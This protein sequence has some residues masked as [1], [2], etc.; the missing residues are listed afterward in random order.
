MFQGDA[1][2]LVPVANA[3]A[4]ANLLTNAGKDCQYVVYPGAQHNFDATSG[5]NANPPAA[6]DAQQKSIAFF[7][8]KMR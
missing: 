5:P 2:Q 6:A 1:D 4:M 3:N 7:E 8:A